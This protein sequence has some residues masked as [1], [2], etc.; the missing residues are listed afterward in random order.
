MNS[1]S[2]YTRTSDRLCSTPLSIHISYH[3]DIQNPIL[4]SVSDCEWYLM[5]M[6]KYSFG[7]VKNSETANCLQ[8]IT[9]LV[10]FMFIICS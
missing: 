2:G 8:L 10:V 9:Y 3:K 1:D 6:H 5:G 4:K 7:F